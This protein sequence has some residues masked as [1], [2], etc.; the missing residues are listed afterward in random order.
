MNT[1]TDGSNVIKTCGNCAEYCQKRNVCRCPLNA[2]IGASETHID[3]P[4][5]KESPAC[6]LWRLKA[7]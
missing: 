3:C 5:T 6:T 4:T 7:V 1:D 2:V